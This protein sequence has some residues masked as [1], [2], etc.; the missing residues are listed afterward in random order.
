MKYFTH[1]ALDARLKEVARHVAGYW[2][3][4]C[5]E[6]A[7]RE[8][9]EM[10]TLRVMHSSPVTVILTKNLYRTS[11]KA[12]QDSARC[13]FGIIVKSGYMRN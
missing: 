1:G 7:L 8:K 5:L 13:D 2:R 10:S 9:R 4:V 12:A 3:K 6:A 11:T